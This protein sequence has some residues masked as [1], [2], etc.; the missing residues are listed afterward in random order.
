MENAERNSQLC[1]S[2]GQKM[3]GQR[4]ARPIADLPQD[5]LRVND[6]HTGRI[7]IS[8]PTLKE[9]GIHH[10]GPDKGEV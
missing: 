10:P 7:A 4:R 8:A 3:G 1:S 5:V 9:L 2:E 6:N